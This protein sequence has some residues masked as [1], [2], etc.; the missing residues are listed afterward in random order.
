MAIYLKGLCDTGDCCPDCECAET[1]KCDDE[2]CIKSIEPNLSPT[3]GMTEK[4]WYETRVYVDTGDTGI[5]M[6]TYC[7]WIENEE[8]LPRYVCE[9]REIEFSIYAWVTMSVIQKATH[10][11][12]EKAYSPKECLTNKGNIWNDNEN[13]W[14]SDSFWETRY[15]NSS[16]IDW[17][18]A[19]SKED[20]TGNSMM[21]NYENAQGLST[22]D[23]TDN[24]H[25]Y[26]Q[27][28]ESVAGN[29]HDA[30]AGSFV[31]YTK[32]SNGN[33][34]DQWITIAGTWLRG[35][36][37]D[38]NCQYYNNISTTCIQQGYSPTQCAEWSSGGYGASACAW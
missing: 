5:E 14:W 4:I 18:T 27:V 12:Y 23:R 35:A 3:T 8:G 16:S 26:F 6:E 38:N 20:G 9:E 37:G 1:C 7:Y 11:E 29:W 21:Q 28:D 24:P 15:Q 33:I 13:V 31:G 25:M 2:Y 17:T 10:R 19:N 34:T 32:D 22:A 36:I 30:G